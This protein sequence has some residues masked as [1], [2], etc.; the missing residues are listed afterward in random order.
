[1]PTT[2]LIARDLYVRTTEPSGK[3]HVAQHR[4][5]DADRFLCSLQLQA[6]EQAAKDKK[7]PDVVTLAT[8]AEYRAA[9]R[10]A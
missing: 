3:S 5:W 9:G 2:E 1:M 10:S 7:K 6:R 8:E 4:V